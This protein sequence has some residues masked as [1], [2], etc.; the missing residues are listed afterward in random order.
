MTE[1]IRDTLEIAGIYPRWLGIGNL[2]SIPANNSNDLPISTNTLFHLGNTKKEADLNIAE[3]FP[4]MTL[5]DD[6][7]IIPDVFAQF[8]NLEAPYVNK[9]VNLTFDLLAFT[10]ID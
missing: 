10:E 2:S 7:I 4:N 8:F 3:G 6:E 9:K 5:A 1:K